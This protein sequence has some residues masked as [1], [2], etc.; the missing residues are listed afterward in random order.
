MGLRRLAGSVGGNIGD[1]RLARVVQRAA[2]R[3]LEQRRRRAGEMARSFVRDAPRGR[4][5]ASNRTRAVES[6]E[7]RLA[8]HE[9]ERKAE[10]AENRAR[11]EAEVEQRVDSPER[12]VAPTLRVDGALRV[13]LARLE[14]LGSP[15]QPH[16]APRPLRRPG[17]V[18]EGGWMCGSTRGLA[19]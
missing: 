19:P 17:S 18:R 4:V 12:K 14:A 8:A 3:G 11:L 16:A 2:Q 7:E 5:H 13:P 9:R 1:Q 6:V 10:R 15:R